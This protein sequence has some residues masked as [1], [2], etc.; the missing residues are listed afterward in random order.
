[1]RNYSSLLVFVGIVCLSAGAHS[2][3]READSSAVDSYVRAG[4]AGARIPGLALGVI[5]DGR[6][7]HLKGY[8]VAGP[9]GRP[10]TSRTPFILG[11]TSKSFTALAVMQLVEAG[12]IE[13]DSPVTR[14]LPWFR[15]QN[16]AESAGITV[17]H[18]L[19]HTSGLQ[20]HDGLQ[21]LWDTDQSRLALENGVRELSR[22]QL[23]QPPGQ[24]YE[25]SNG[26]YN[27]LGLIVQTVSGMSFE[28]YVRSAIFTPL[29][30]HHSAAA[31]SDAAVGDV[32]AGYRHWLL[33][34]VAFEAPYPRRMT[35]AGFL[36]SSAEDLSH[37]VD[38]LL[39]DGVFEGR[40]LL[41]PHGIGTLY[42]PGSRISSAISYG[43]GWA[44]GGTPESRTIWHD[45]DVSNF[46]SHIRLL[47]GQRH[48]L[49]VL[50]N[51]G[52]PGRTGPLSDCVDGIAAKA[53]EVGQVPPNRSVESALSRLAVLLPVVIA[54][55][56]AVWL[57]RSS[58]RWRRRGEPSPW[59][60]R[61]FWRIYVP[62]AV[63][64]GA[65][66]AM[67]I[68]LPATLQVPIAAI[69]LLVPDVF[70]F[71]V[72]T[73]AIVLGC[74]ATRIVLAVR[75]FDGSA[76]RVLPADRALLTEGD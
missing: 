75:P 40:Q 28:E 68:L 47:P 42:A 18:L 23:R 13:L 37:Y 58:H 62:L 48:G 22:S 56:W 61:R 73:T 15:T 33:W 70:A 60:L 19:H 67:W 6:I 71:G 45:G 69:A 30:M 52:G 12:R 20:T 31:R 5:R 10:V 16:A 72:I 8:G 57:Y 49:I 25:Y 29:R 53:F 46:H 50:M 64:L 11:S 7:V 76:S 44:I 65:V 9:D 74:A 63:E 1:M 21:G 59:G 41:S 36:I 27:T 66:G 4:M 35:P 54:M 43:M 39:N 17:R 26:N 38:A 24:R 32:A 3:P 34:P 2:S 55:L 51:V 14:Y